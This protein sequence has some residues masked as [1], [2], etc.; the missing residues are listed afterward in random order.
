MVRKSEN[1][2]LLLLTIF[3]F[4]LLAPLAVGTNLENA[5]VKLYILPSPLRKKY[6]KGH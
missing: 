4:A 2:S 5:D 1:F 3:R 6:F